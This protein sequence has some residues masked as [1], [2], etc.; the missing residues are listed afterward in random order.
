MGVFFVFLFFFNFY[1]VFKGYTSF[2]VIIDFWLYS[3][4]CTIHLEDCGILVP[5]LCVE[6]GP[7]ALEMW[8]PNYL[9]AREFPDSI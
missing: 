4:C 2:T 1:T 7:C 5:C 8:S 9:T 6:P 3:P